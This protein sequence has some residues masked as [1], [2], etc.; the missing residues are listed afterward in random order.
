MLPDLGLDPKGFLSEP[1]VN[2]PA[3]LQGDLTVLTR[4]LV[5]D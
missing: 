2:H 3:L 5:W 4:L 1:E